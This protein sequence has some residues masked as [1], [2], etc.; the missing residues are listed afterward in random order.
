MHSSLHLKTHSYLT[1]ACTLHTVKD[2]DECGPTQN[3]NLLKTLWDFKKCFYFCDFI[4]WFS[5]MNFVK[6][7]KIPHRWCCLPPAGKYSW[8][9]FHL[10]KNLFICV[11]VCVYLQGTCCSVLR[12]S[13]LNLCQPNP[14]QTR[15]LF[16]TSRVSEPRDLERKCAHSSELAGLLWLWCVDSSIWL[17]FYPLNPLLPDTRGMNFRI[18][19]A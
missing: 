1:Y 11:C 15:W 10:Y 19:M 13:G 14:R 18:A 2:S 12:G 16:P 9:W 3:L 5:S 4:T 17:Q 6:G 7:L 8:K